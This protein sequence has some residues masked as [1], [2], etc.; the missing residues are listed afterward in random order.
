YDESSARNSFHHLL[1]EPD[2]STRES[3]ESIEM[4]DE[5][6]RGRVEVRGPDSPPPEGPY[7]CEYDDVFCPHTLNVL[8][9]M[10]SRTI[11]RSRG[12]IISQYYNRTLKLRRKKSRPTLQNMPRSSRPSIRECDWEPGVMKDEEEERRRLLTKELQVLSSNQRVRMLQMMP[13]SLRE[14]RDLHVCCNERECRNRLHEKGEIHCCSQIKYSLIKGFRHSWFEFLSFLHMLQLWHYP[15]KQIGGRFGTSVLSYFI[16]LKTLLLFS[17]FLFIGNLF[18][19]VVPQAV[20]P[21]VDH[22]NNQ[23]FTGLELFTGAGYFTDTVLYYGYYSNSTLTE[24]CS[25][26]ANSTQC[27][28]DLSHTLPYNLPLAYIFTIGVAFFITCIALVYSMSKSFGDSYRVNS[29][30]GDLAVKVFCSWDFKVIQKR[31]IKVQSDNICTQL[32]ELLADLQRKSSPMSLRK[33]FGKI[34]IEFFAWMLALGSVLGCTFAVYRCSILLLENYNDKLSQNTMLKEASLLALP[35]MVSSI[36]LLMPY[37]YNAM[38]ILERDE[39]PEIQLYAAICRNLLLKMTVLGMLCY[40]WLVQVTRQP[41]KC[42][43]TFVG[44]ELYRFVIMDFIFIILDTIFGELVWRIISETWLKSK[45]KPE[46][47]IARNVLELI[48]GQTLAWLGVLFCP[49]LAGIQIIKLIL[50]F[51]IKK[52]SLVMNCQSPR[53]PWRASHMTTLFITL[54]C[55]PSF[56]GAAV[57]IS[58]TIWWMKPSEECGPFRTLTTIY[59]S[60]K[61]WVRRLEKSNPRFYWFSWIHR[62]LVENPL[63]IFTAAGILLIVIYFHAEVV[64]GQRKIIR[65]LREQIA[66]EGEDKKFL[67]N[68]LQDSYKKINSSPGKR[69]SRE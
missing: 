65:L 55:F 36:N 34:V 44:Q 48:Y 59:E 27:A 49:L 29:A 47:D 28:K 3:Y 7:L 11:G 66:N 32:K 14:K 13:L 26:N 39:S 9:A 53:K 68:K 52:T 24:Q 33:R 40:H 50:I 61:V 5:L 22:H 54:L 4:Q 58:Y 64:D 15:L 16:F 19:I 60:G 31:S 43:E 17:V 57:S 25:V 38:R 8:S 12:A 23:T 63:V 18:F 41:Q 10:P 20:Y 67:I 30:S 21:P 2:R 62:H 45:R 46:F 1:Q 35:L 42:W 51:Y 37:V 56:L 6:D 69:A